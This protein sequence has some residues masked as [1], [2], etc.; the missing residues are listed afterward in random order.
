[1]KKQVFLTQIQHSS[2]SRN[3]FFKDMC[4][5]MVPTNI[6]WFKLQMLKFRPFLE[7]YCKP[8]IPEES[9][10]Q[11][12][13][14]PICCKE[15][16]ENIWGNKGDAIIWVAVDETTDSVVALLWTLWL[17]SYTLKFLL[18]HIWFAQKFCTIQIIPLLQHLWM[19]DLK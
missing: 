17:A 5:W 6:P 7:K 19:M 14:L 8:R 4:N 3:D 9:R 18:I 2:T 16:L 12:H 1:L 15:T 11:K 10:I 13:N